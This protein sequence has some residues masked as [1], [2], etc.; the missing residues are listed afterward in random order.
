MTAVARRLALSV[1]ALVVGSVLIFS[2]AEA[3]PGDAAEA[4]LGRAATPEA[5]AAKRKE[6]GLDRSFVQRYGD[7]MADAVRG[8]LGDSLSAHRPVWE[9]V[10]PR[11]KNSLLL[12]AF[13][14]LFTVP[15]SVVLGL[16]S[17]LRNG[18]WLDGT[19]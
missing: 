5:L 11:L 17:G 18:G 13:A 16:L 14:V 15:L 6:L 3:L 19:I 10:E 2:A 1:A 12:A 7:W 8:D 9:L 4:Q